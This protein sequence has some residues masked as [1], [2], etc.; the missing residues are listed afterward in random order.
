MRRRASDASHI[1]SRCTRVSLA[2]ALALVVLGACRDVARA[3]VILSSDDVAVASSDDAG[4]SMRGY[5]L[6]DMI[7]KHVAF[8]REV[9]RATTSTRA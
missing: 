2:R 6:S 1:R 7:A 5:S 3:E 9:R 4:P 8:P